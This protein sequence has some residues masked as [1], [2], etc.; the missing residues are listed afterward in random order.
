MSTLFSSLNKK[1][2]LLSNLEKQVLDYMI[3]NPEKVVQLKV[4]ELAE[5]LYVSTA[6]IT[7]TAQKLGMSGYQE[8]KYQINAHL[9]GSFRS[10]HQGE[11]KDSLLKGELLASIEESLSLDNEIK[12]KEAAKRLK[13]ARLIEVFSVG[14]SAAIGMDF[15]K[16]LLHLGNYSSAKTDW[17]ELFTTSNQL[18]AE[19]AVVILSQS[20]ETLQLLNY[21]NNV[22]ESQTPIISVTANPHSPLALLSDVSIVVKT[23]PYYEKEVDL[24]SRI[25]L[26]AVMDAIAIQVSKIVS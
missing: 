16:K 21:A 20:G 24:S 19:D 11:P 4:N 15:S 12:I 22:K 7:R 6:T 9:E 1:R 5:T 14:G 13:D 26:M 8:L 23:V 17:D 3:K 18:T 10:K 25:S 2:N